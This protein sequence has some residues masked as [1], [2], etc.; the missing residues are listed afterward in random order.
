MYTTLNNIIF[1]NY[2]KN[3]DCFVTKG[4]V[5]DI[6]S[7]FDDVSF[8][9]AHDKHSSIISDIDIK[10]VR[11]F[12]IPFKDVKK[13]LPYIFHEDSGTLFI[14][15]WIGSWIGKYLAPHHHANFPLLHIAWKEYYNI[16][17]LDDNEDF[18]YYLPT[19]DY[20]K[21]DTSK[22]D[23]YLEKINNRPMVLF[24]N[25]I[26]QS[27]QSAMSTM[28]QTIELVAKKFADYEFLVCHKSDLNLP[29]VTY[30]DDIF[31]SNEGNMNEIS[32]LSR[33][34]KM[35]VGKNSGP[36]SFCHTKENLDDPSKIFLSFNFRPTDCLTG[37]GEY[38]ANTFFSNT[39][40]EQ[41]AA[42]MVTHF[43]LKTDY[44]VGKKRLLTVGV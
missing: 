35:I 1:Y 26:Q 41:L 29:N 9:Y 22:C 33:S 30:T 38:N 24:C 3:G 16:L 42:E 17:G 34:A 28:K 32:Y 36:F 40:N 12:Q 11:T 44:S 15:T 21:Y 43:L 31:G 10:I 7:K 8:S 18:N 20:S 23:E 19:I 37:A 39:V 5:K 4:F 6:M 27:G 13:E 2:E 25:G 14:S